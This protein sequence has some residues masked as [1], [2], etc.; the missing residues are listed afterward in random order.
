MDCS[1]KRLHKWQHSDEIEGK[2]GMTYGVPNDIPR[3]VLAKHN[4]DN[5]DL[6][7]IPMY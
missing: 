3:P 4:D 6:A 2:I 7:L 1:P 5:I